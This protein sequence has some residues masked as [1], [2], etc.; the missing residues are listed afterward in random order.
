[1]LRYLIVS[2]LALG[3]LIAE[4]PTYDVERVIGPTHLAMF[5]LD[6]VNTLQFLGISGSPAVSLKGVL[7]ALMSDDPTVSRWKLVLIYRTTS[8]SVETK[9]V[10][11]DKQNNP[12][13]SWSNGVIWV[14]ADPF[15]VLSVEVTEEH[16][17]ARFTI[18]P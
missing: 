1:M 10:S 7:F 11:I 4:T 12:S 18:A 5:A 17:L 15:T 2:L 13:S 14:S 9:R 3:S 16:P 8:S 6:P